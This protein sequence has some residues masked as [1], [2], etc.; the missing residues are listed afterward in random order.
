MP[1]LSMGRRR[2]RSHIAFVCAV[3]LIAAACDDTNTPTGSAHTQPT[4]AWELRVGDPGMQQAY[5][6]EAC[7]A[8]GYVVTGTDQ[9]DVLLVRI[10][11]FGQVVWETSFGT[12]EADA[13]SAVAQ[14]ADGGF[15]VAGYT[16]SAGGDPRATMLART[17]T[18]GNLLW[19]KAYGGGF[20]DGAEAV[21]E[22]PGG[23]LL[24]GASIPDTG[25]SGSKFALIQTDDSGN[26][27]WTRTYG[28]SHY[29]ELSDM[30][31]TPDGGYLMVGRTSS[32][33]VA[34][35][36]LY[37]VKVS[38]TGDLLWQKHYGGDLSE[39]GTG[40][41][42]HATGGYI[43]SGTTNESPTPPFEDVFLLRV[44]DTGTVIWESRLGDSGRVDQGQAMALSRTGQIVVAGGTTSPGGGSRDMLCLVASP[45]G[46]LLSIGA[47]GGAWYDDALS[48]VTAHDK[49]VLVAGRSEVVY[50]ID[51][52]AY[53]V[54]VLVD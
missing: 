3:G 42:V 11:D 31:E 8:G 10:D 53:I 29:D 45:A 46:E 37:A 54:K 51:W 36:A 4:I 22:S 50:G 16:D 34:T 25:I 12:S 6:I 5:R 43:L 13:G 21:F 47:I 32:F 15:A 49:G 19:L 48:A 35:T 26:V 52:D 9:G 27:A 1:G 14:L 38:A 39:K 40:A 41:A 20:T 28:G 23:G 44:D 30:I 24:V 33:G 2:S 7:P 17:D 18:L